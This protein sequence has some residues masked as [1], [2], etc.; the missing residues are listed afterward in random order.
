MFAYPRAARRRAVIPGKGASFGSGT[1]SYFLKR[2]FDFFEEVEPIKI[3]LKF[4]G[5]RRGKLQ[6]TF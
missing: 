3:K 2:R 6:I 1:F 4:I 5:E